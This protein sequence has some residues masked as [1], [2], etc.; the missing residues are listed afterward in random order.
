[1]QNFIIINIQKIL[2]MM[3]KDDYQHFV[4]IVAGSN[5]EELMKQYDKNIPD[6]PYVVYKYKDV[7]KI[8]RGKPPQR[9]DEYGTSVISIQVFKEG[10]FISIKNRYNH[11]V[12]NCDNT[13]NSN[14]DNIILGLSDAIKHHFHVF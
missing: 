9:D 10:G 6:I 8:K 14:P 4:C 2:I 11:T 12:Q 5:P 7:D 1:M 13:L 3:T